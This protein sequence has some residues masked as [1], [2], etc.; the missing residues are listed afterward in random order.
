[1]LPE[2]SSLFDKKPE[3]PIEHMQAN[4]E[5]FTSG[6]QQWLPE[7]MHVWDAFVAEA[8][9]II[10]KGYQH[11]SARTIIEVLRHH[12]ALHESSGEW[13]LNN[14]HPPYLARL[15]DLVYPQHAGLFE[16]RETKKVVAEKY[17]SG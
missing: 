12:S 5:I 3:T 7:N 17:G 9:A 16:Y 15:F 1:M 13:K 8:F 6:F 11:Y 10:R 14:D 2:Q 4:A